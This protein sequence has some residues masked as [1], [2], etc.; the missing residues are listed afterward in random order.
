MK[1]L[2]IEGGQIPSGKI[3]ISGAKNSA[4]RILAAASMLEDQVILNN[5]PT[6]LID[7]LEKVKFLEV[8]GIKVSLNTFNNTCLINTNKV[9]E[10]TKKCDFNIQIRTTYLLAA[11]QLKYFG[12]ALI[13]YPGGCKIG[14]RKYDLHI[15]V[16]KRFGCTVTEKENYILIEAH[17]GYLK[18]ATIN[19]PITTVGGTENAL[20]CGSIVNETSIIDNAYITPEVFDLVQFLRLAG[21]TIQIEGS[22]K[23]IITGNKNLKL[24]SY[25]IVHDRI[26][27]LTWMIYGAMSGGQVEIEN[28]PFG[29]MKI[30][31]NYLDYT[32]ID[33]FSNSNSV[34]INPTCIKPCG[35]QPFELAGGTYPGIV[36]DMMPFYVLLALKAG[37]RSKVFDYRYPERNIFCHELN[38]FCNNSIN[39]KSGEIIINGPVKFHAAKCNSTDLRGS[40]VLILAALIANE[41]TSYINNPEMALRGYNKLFEKLNKLGIMTKIQ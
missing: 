3:Q 10:V 40:M 34:F 13:P 20:M 6:E 26:E 12:K 2:L 29:I 16:W 18:P 39:Y 41:G 11:P 37:G 36:S 4:L 30:P 23:I 8:M 9:K 28:I 24:S 25:E 38:K 1:K 21:A 32:G 19:F 14:T 27:A 15:E 5:F 35:I 22:S 33:Y 31:L 17:K 7:T